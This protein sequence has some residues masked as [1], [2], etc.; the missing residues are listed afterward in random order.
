MKV[1][2]ATTA[3][4]R[5]HGDAQGSFI[6]EA[7]RAI[8]RQ[9]V[10]V[11]V[12]AMHVPGAAT[13]EM[14]E[15]V[16]VF[17]PRYLRPERWE[18]L[19]REGGGLPIIW[20]KYPWARALFLP[21]GL[22]HTAAI[23]RHA[24][25]CDLVHAQWT[26]SAAAA[27]LGRPMH[28]RP[29]VATLQGSDIFQA[30]RSPLGARFTRYAIGR[31]EGLTVLSTALAQ[32]TQAAG[33]PAGRIRIIP[34]GVATDQWTPP[35]DGE[36]A[37][38]L[39]YVGSFIERKGVRHLLGAAP[40]LLQRLPGYRLVLIGDGPQEAELRE[41]AARSG[42][43]EQIEFRGFL[44]QE[45]VR[46]AMQRARVFILPSLEE[47]LGVV[48]L[49][50]LACGTPIVASRVDGIVDVVTDDVG[51]LAPPSD[52]EQLGAGVL[53]VLASTEH[54][55]EF[56]R[57]ARVRAVEHY[58]WD[59]IARQFVTLYRSIVAASHSRTPPA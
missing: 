22:V 17:R 8:A 28:R 53:Q 38:E 44:P 4:P 3:F 15:D 7:A 48:L 25:D 30:A 55:R 19:R 29:I 43:A 13:H 27:R 20:R 14:M 39:L 1:C 21:F 9:G 50:A 10:A 56:S 33:I 59:H 16:E 34:N 57:A 45:E 12:V 5:W 54:W 6:W 42:F 2:I 26:L 31:C 51:V 18:I 52:P 32:A 46:A 24:R 37:D 40:D 23:A 11:R 35:P 58:D 49:E 47:G 36:R 41:M